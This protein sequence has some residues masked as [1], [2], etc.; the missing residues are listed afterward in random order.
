MEIAVKVVAVIAVALLLFVPSIIGHRRR[1]VAFG[2]ISALN[3][4]VLLT[5]MHTFF[6]WWFG[7][8]TAGLWLS[9]TIWASAA[10]T[11]SS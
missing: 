7:L 9:A 3:A 10:K 5:A 2:S 11:K 4:L 1:I 6:W 8:I